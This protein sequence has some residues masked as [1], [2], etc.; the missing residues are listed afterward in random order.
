MTI[1]PNPPARTWRAV[2]A[3][4]ATAT[5]AA[6]LVPA[7]AAQAATPDVV[8]QGAGVSCRRPSSAPTSSKPWSPCAGR[9]PST[10]TIGGRHRR[11]APR[12]PGG[13]R[14]H[15]RA[16]GLDRA[17]RGQR[18]HPPRRGGAVRPRQRRRQLLGVLRRRLGRP[19]SDRR[20]YDH[21]LGRRGPDRR[22]LRNHR[23][24]G[25]RP[26]GGAA[27]R[28]RR[29]GGIRRQHRR[30]RAERAVH[31]LR[32]GSRRRRHPRLGRPQYI[33]PA[34]DA[35]IAAAGPL[36]LDLDN[37]FASGTIT[38]TEED[39]LAAAGVDGIEDLDPGTDL[40]SFVP[41]PSSTRSPT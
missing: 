11:S 9:T 25:H 16:G 17:V 1:R 23:R 22:R 36:G 31:R 35:L 8:S 10:P 26:A 40:L 7:T 27:R 34:L 28:R 3:V 19:Q 14:S 6:L 29:A 41:R 30:R 2:R 18:H 39:L 20:R 32:R 15:R 24:R 38:L 37:P 13:R 5:V 4:G 33:S 21:A 12:R